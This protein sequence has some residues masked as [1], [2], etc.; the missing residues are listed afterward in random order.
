MSNFGKGITVASGFDLG[1]KTPLD[2][3]LVVNTIEELSEHIENNRAYEGMIVYVIEKRKFYTYINSSWNELSTSGTGGSGGDG[4]IHVGL[5]LPPTNEYVWIDTSTPSKIVITDYSE[6]LKLKYLEALILTMLR[7]EGLSEKINLI[8]KNINEISSDNYEK[9]INFKTTLSA[10][11][12]KIQT[13]SDDIK[14]IYL[15]LSENSLDIASI[16]GE[17]KKLRKEVKSTVFLLIDFNDEIMRVLD[18]ELKFNDSGDGDNDNII[19]NNASI[20]TEDGVALLTEDGLLILAD[21]IEEII[22]PN[23]A[24]IT[25]SGNPLLTE[26][27]L[28]LLADEIDK[29]ETLVDA[30]LTELGYVLMTENGKQIL[31]G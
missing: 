19:T 17:I 6:R 10:T 14:N 8:E 24:I 11:K 2:S 13:L 7:L 27:G 4:Y 23:N 28:I 22:L 20:L 29:N 3:R 21:G 25:E 1:A 26:S 15:Q 18:G 12:N 31:K 30:I 16:K 9:I 5:D